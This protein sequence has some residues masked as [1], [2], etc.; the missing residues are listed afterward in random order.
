VDERGRFARARVQSID[1]AGDGLLAPDASACAHEATCGGCRFQRA[2]YPLELEWKAAAALDP[3][4]RIGRG[5]AWPEPVIVGA[6]APTG[7]RGRARMRVAR[8]G[9]TG[10]VGR[11]S[12]E[13]VAIETCNVLLPALDAARAE[14]GALAA[15]IGPTDGVVIEWDE[16]REQVAVCLYL[17]APLENAK[18]VANAQRIAREASD[19]I[20]TIVATA[21]R[22]RVA[23][24]GDGLVLQPMGDR[25]VTVPA[26]SF[27]QANLALNRTLVE[28]A[29]EAIPPG[30]RVL[31][32]FAG[33]GNF[34]FPLL[35]RGCTVRAIEVAEPALTAAK[36]A[37][38]LAPAVDD[39]V[40]FVAH[41]LALGVPR[42]ARSRDYG[43]VL[44][45]P[46]R[47]GMRACVRGLLDCA[48]PRIV[49][50]SCDPPTLARDV[51][52]LGDGGYA[53]T[54]LHLVDMFPRTHHIE[55]V[56]VLDRA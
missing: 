11:R 27:R 8:D 12:N 50:V 2:P 42:A 21:G 10:F 37:A 36:A 6:P 29:T 56:A 24:V 44:A 16:V 1:D 51:A 13:P 46:P 54:S 43:A 52:M 17:R 5:V 19:A 35:A 49:Y 34:T 38:G 20:S 45:D 15:R 9:R 47:T 18:R 48:A 39:R 22:Q 4:R 23:L 3:M 31:E 41:D 25:V 7:Y 55:A 26:G 40:R 28:I 33:A 53:V 14:V 32:L 30:S